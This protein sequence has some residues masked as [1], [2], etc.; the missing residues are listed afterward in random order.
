MIK[1][2]Q[3]G[4]GDDTRTWSPPSAT[5]PPD[6]E[7]EKP[8]SAY[9]LACNRNKRSLTLDFKKE[10]GREIVRRLVKTAD[11]LVE[12]YIPG[13]LA[14][15]SLSYS[16][17]SAINPRLIYASITGYGQ[18]GPYAKRA[19]YDVVIEAEA[20]LMHITG[21]PDPSPPAKV[22]VA[23]TDLT[24]GLYAKSA[25]LAALLSRSQTG[26]GCWLDINLF[27]SQLSSLANI[28][29]NYLVA[30]KEASRHGTSHPSVVPYQ[31]FECKDGWLMIGAG[32]ESQFKKLCTALSIPGISSDPRFSTNSQRVKHRDILIPLLTDALKLH[33]RSALLSILEHTGIPHG[34]INSI[35]ETFAHPQAEAREVVVT[36]PHHKVQNGVKMVAPPV[37]YNGERMPVR[38]P[39]PMLGEHTEEVLK[40]LGYVD[41]DVEQL[42]VEGVI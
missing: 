16:D 27:E 12:N 9:F 26:K 4:L 11:I 34:P 31:V 6:L 19:G 28:A 25:I 14:S 32:N 38:R 24:T 29:S 21:H 8:E 13:K 37:R 3:R 39:P 10:A 33:T 2:E 30:G 18:T 23:L 5:L 1:I 17:L 41:G 20:G 36:V 40:E 35:A 7:G 15:Y 22:G 42:K